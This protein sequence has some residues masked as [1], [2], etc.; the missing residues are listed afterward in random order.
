MSRVSG[1]SQPRTLRIASWVRLRNLCDGGSLRVRI[2]RGRSA[3]RDS[4]PDKAVVAAGLWERAL[5]A[6]GEGKH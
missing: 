5:G 3:A 1:H 6:L 4:C 2:C